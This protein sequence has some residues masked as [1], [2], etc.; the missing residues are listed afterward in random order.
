MSAGRHDHHNGTQ[1]RPL[2]RCVSMLIL[3]VIL[4]KGDLLLPGPCRMQAGPLYSLS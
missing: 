4:Q 3:S 2:R 1:G